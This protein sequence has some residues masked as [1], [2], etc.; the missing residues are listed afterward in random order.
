MTCKAVES[1]RSAADAIGQIEHGSRLFCVLRGQWSMADAIHHVIEWDI[2]YLRSQPS[3]FR[4]LLIASAQNRT[5]ANARAG[6]SYYAWREAFGPDSVRFTVS[7]AKMALV[8]SATRRILIR[9]SANANKNQRAEQYDITEGGADYELV[10]RMVGEFEERDE[11]ATL[12]DISRACK[13][14]AAPAESDGAFVG[15]SRWSL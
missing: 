14:G 15:C 6:S 13:L 5:L 12:A 8:R 9:G 2:E 11:A 3:I 10:E 7:H 1:Y 4:G